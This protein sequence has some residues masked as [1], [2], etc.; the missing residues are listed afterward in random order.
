MLRGFKLGAVIQISKMLAPLW[1]HAAE[2]PTTELSPPFLTEKNQCSWKNKKDKNKKH[3]MN[4]SCG[5]EE[6]EALLAYLL[7]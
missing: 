6:L 4:V 1:K 2:Q 5:T 7:G 3:D